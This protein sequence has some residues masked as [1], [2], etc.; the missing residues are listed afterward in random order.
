MPVFCYR[1]SDMPNCYNYLVKYPYIAM[2]IVC[3][4]TVRYKSCTLPELL[5]I[6]ILVLLFYA[7][8]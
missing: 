4:N 3:M 5:F 1:L 2:V 7:A 8:I 6:D